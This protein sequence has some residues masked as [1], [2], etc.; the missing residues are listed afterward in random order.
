M[1]ILHL[2]FNVASQISVTVR[3][4]RDLGMNARGVVITDSPIQDNKDLECFP[5]GQYERHSIQG[6]L[7][8]LLFIPVFKRAVDW[9]DVIHWHFISMDFPWD[10]DLKYLAWFKKPRVVEFWGSD[11]RVPEIASAD[12]PYTDRMYQMYPDIAKGDRKRSY[13]TQRAFSAHGFECLIPDFEM[14][15]YL[16]KDL[17]PSFHR[18]KARI[19]LS[20]FLPI[21]PEPRKQRPLIVHA[22]SRKEI[23]GTKSIIKAVDE[24]KAHLDFDFQL[25]HGVPHANAIKILRSSDIVID[26]IVSGSFGLLACEAMALGKPVVGYIKPS[27]LSQHP[28]IFPIVNANEKNLKEI[29]KYLITDGPKRH[30]IGKMGRTYV[31]N[32]HDAHKVAAQL[33]EIYKGKLNQ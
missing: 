19:I 5:V 28:E 23:K 4:L 27:V 16:K 21:Y 3:A 31:E 33:I 20:D 18:T 13:K 8:R 12:N 26:E 32:F 6:F 17:F 29:L 11:I 14:E 2:P 25:I 22:P 7:R 9:A 15:P 10:L 1:K 24:L 30:E